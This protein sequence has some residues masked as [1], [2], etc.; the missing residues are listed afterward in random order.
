MTNIMKVMQSQA[1]CLIKT[2]IKWKKINYAHNKMSNELGYS[3]KVKGGG[4]FGSALATVSFYKPL[5]QCP[6]CLRYNVFLV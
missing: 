3:V 5:H 6:G 4:P 2:A 1:I